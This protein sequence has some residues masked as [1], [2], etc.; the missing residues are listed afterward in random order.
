MALLKSVDIDSGKRE[1]EKLK[2]L[3]NHS[4]VATINQVFES[5][6]LMYFRFDYS[7]FTLEE[8]LNVHLRLDESHLRII[9]SSIFLAIKHIATSG[10]VH[11]AIS[12]AT[13]RFSSNG[14]PLLSNFENCTWTTADT[15]S[16]IDFA[17]LGSCI[18]ECMNGKPSED[19][20]DPAQ[21]RRKRESNKMFG[22]SNGESWSGYKLLVDFLET[23]FNNSTPSIVKLEKPH[24]YVLQQPGYRTLTPFLEL[25]SLE[26]HAIWRRAAVKQVGGTDSAI[27]G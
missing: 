13:I 1:L 8:I 20:R 21:I 10:I 7:R 11:T 5:G 17:G 14:R 9:A 4:H 23:L 2:M 18:L 27:H 19:L 12:I 16:N 3:S 26:C 25:A 6:D 15:T 22:L 24:P